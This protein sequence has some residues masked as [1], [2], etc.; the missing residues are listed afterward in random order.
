VASDSLEL[1]ITE[2]VLMSGD[3]HI[4]DAM[5]ALSRLGVT[6]A[7][8]DFGTGYSSLSYLRNYPFNTLKIDRSFIDDITVN[9]ADRELVNASIKMARNLGLTVVAEGVKTEEQLAV[10]VELGCGLAQGY[11]FG[12]PVSAEEIQG[13]LATVS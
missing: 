4:D 6:T 7:M 5:A 12:K 1:E 8:D 13:M 10:L 11:L 2:G 3:T 9:P